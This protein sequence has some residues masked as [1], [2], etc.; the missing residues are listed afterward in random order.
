MTLQAKEQEGWP[1]VAAGQPPA[2]EMRAVSKAFDGKPA[3][4]DAFFDLAWG[5][6]HA[7]VGENGAGK[8]TLMNVA[9]GVYA[10]DSGEQAVDGESISPRSPSEATAAGIGMVHQ[11]FRLVDSFTVAENVLLG[12]G[13]HATIRS[14]AQAAS[15]IRAKSTEIGLPVDPLRVVSTLS[16]AERQRAEIVK[17]LLLGARIL[18]LDEPTAV[19]TEE[20]AEALLS[21]IRRLAGQGHAIV[22]ITH[23]FREVAAFCD[24]ITIMRHGKTVLAGTVVADISETD[25]GRLMVGE[26][27]ASGA[28]PVW[29]PGEVYLRVSGLSSHDGTEGQG[30]TDMSFDLRAGEVLGIAGVGGNGQEALVSCMLGLSA[31]ADGQILIGDVDITTATP[32]ERRL[33]GL[34]VVPADRFATGLIRD[35]SIAENLALTRVCD[36]EFGSPLLLRRKRMR[37]NAE[38]AIKEFDIRGASPAR[39]TALLSGGNAQKVLLA[40]EL[41]RDMTVLVAHSPSRGLDIKSTQFVRAAIQRA[42]E[43]GAACLLISEDLQEILSLSHRVAVM[44]RGTIVGSCDASDVTSDWIGALLAGHA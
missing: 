41:D 25:V 27:L 8:S 39:S 31:P 19:L 11:H 23:K 13:R 9:A 30:I 15:A 38:S 36:G 26:T 6:V 16:I 37:L 18:V 22:L 17:V 24:R 4:I 44:N 3:L 5:E 35:L 33:A 12:L 32:R 40:R 21:F 28:P 42:V 34:R 29:V 10:A 20:E 1:A 43:N 14:I 7:I 2:L